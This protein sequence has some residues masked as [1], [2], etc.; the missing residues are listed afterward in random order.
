VASKV[1]P[2]FFS[3]FRLRV[4]AALLADAE[5]GGGPIGQCFAALLAAF[6]RRLMG[7]RL[8]AARA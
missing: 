3:A 5:L 7:I 4:A 8:G 2:L 1:A 6:F